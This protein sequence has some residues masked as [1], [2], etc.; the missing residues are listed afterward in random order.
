MRQIARRGWFLLVAALL[1]GAARPA[2]AAAPDRASVQ[3]LLG[4]MQSAVAA[5]DLDGLLGAYDSRDEALVTRAGGEAQ[6]WFALEG[7]RVK[8]RLGSLTPS[9]ESL[10]AVVLREV[11]YREHGRDQI[12]GR[13]E[14]VQLHQL[15]AGWKI[16]SEAERTFARATSTELRVELHPEDGTMRG[17][18]R[19]E[20]E[21]T[22][23]G[24][25]SLLLLLNRGLAV[26]SI[27]DGGG[28]TVSFSREADA[29]SVPQKVSL[30]P[31][32]RRT[33]TIEF[34]GTLFNESRE[35][36]YSQVSIAP[37]GSFASWV[38]EWYPR[39]QGS[40]SKSPGRIT[41]DV[42]EGVTVASSGRLTENRSTG[43]RSQQVFSVD[44][45]LDFSF[46]AARYFH[47]EKTVGGVRLGM[48]L[49]RGGEAKAE[50]YLREGTRILEYEQSLYG[51]YPF[52]GYAVVEIPSDVT[53]GLGGSS[54]QGMNLFPVGVLPESGFPLLL[55]AHEMGHS[56]WG[57][58]VGSTG[59]PVI[60]EGLAQ[61]S[62]VLCLREFQ[63]EQ[64]MRSFLKN[65]VPGYAQS[66]TQYFLRFAGPGR[67]DYPLS[68]TAQGGDARAAIHDIADTK[69]MFVY[70]M[71]REQIGHAPFVAGLRSVVER[72]AGRNVA[73]GDLR[74]AWERTS[75]Q[76]LSSFWRQW[77]DRTGAPDLTLDWTVKPDGKGFVVSGTISQQGAPYDL[78]AEVALAYPGRHDTR[79]V[80][81]SGASTPFSFPTEQKPEWV[82]LD[83]EYK[84]L[85]WTPALR[86]A[87]LLADGIGL[88]SMG[89]SEEAIG[90][91]SDYVGKV[92]EGLE[93]R[94]QLGV[95]YQEAGKLGDAERAFR[96]VLDRHASLGV[97][98][99]AVTQSALHLGQVL[100]LAGRREEALAAYRRTL[101]LPDQGTAH[102]E[103]RAG[104]GAPFRRKE[105]SPPP[106]RE[107][108]A[109]YAGT[110]DGGQ[111][112]SFRVGLDEHGVLTVSQAGR[113]TA[114]LIWV[115]GSKFRVPGTSAIVLDFK[116][117]PEPSSVDVDAGGLRLHLPKTK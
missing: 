52:D 1:A 3:K 2:S 36:G 82:V 58:L 24:E 7:A 25:D 117:G 109:R 32:Q 89:R 98:E 55:V 60:D 85:R 76:H 106:T 100:D 34:A 16:T 84:I 41:F 75:G 91:L 46:A 88:S 94:Y 96:G 18:S 115:D 56:W 9:Q 65:G 112:I 78:R 111:G 74:A 39:L 27:R 26:K 66:A 15:A 29:I 102:E 79:T 110:Y 114:P 105:R 23:P 44:R 4:R 59:E 113:P 51:P 61:T 38:T 92:P 42:P 12:E 19:L 21:V 40:G 63:G 81:V 86:N 103:A 95:A 22:A 97:Y 107:L 64:A 104:L 10:D 30:E 13:W 93:G 35:Q 57:N 72:F 77:M 71:L 48:Y 70:E 49:L 45:P 62:A 43:G 80:T 67:K 101:D 14:T 50:L 68:A 99:P 31:G 83:P 87:R 28:R 8:Y 11:R 33:F 17:S 90:K 6:G 47:R 116:G 5:R 37:A 69:G 73:L 20:V 108:L 54:E 53:G